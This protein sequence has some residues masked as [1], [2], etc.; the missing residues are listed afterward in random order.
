M[1]KENL[2]EQATVEK[3]AADARIAERAR[4]EGILNC[5]AASGRGALASHLAMKTEM[6]VEQAVAILAASPAEA[7]AAE[8]AAAEPAAPAANQFKTAMD[9][10]RHPE[11]GADS[12]GGES[13]GS[14]GGESAETAASQILNAQAK[15]RGISL[16]H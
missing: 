16:K 11:V 13:A 8:P 5:E 6:S 7:A 9:A 1:S 2:P 4:I 12:A 15:A 3:A 10:D 14:A